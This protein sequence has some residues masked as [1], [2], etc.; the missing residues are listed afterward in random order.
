MIVR[1]YQFAAGGRKKTAGK[2]H[3]L[4]DALGG[5]TKLHAGCLDR[6][7]RVS[8]ALISGAC[9]EAP[10]FE[11]CPA[12]PQL[13]YVVMDEA[14]DRDQ[15]RQHLQEQEVTPII[16]PMRH[17][18]QAIVYDAE[19][20]QLCQEIERS[21]NKIKPF[22]RIAIRYEKLRQTCLAFTQIVSL[23]VMIKQFV[24]PT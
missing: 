10:V 1:A 18:K 9:H 7:I 24:N 21:F 4:W 15:I 13:A 14:C 2:R 17:R 8:L 23:W 20:Y 19:Q 16:L 22:H 11:R 12:M 3:R 6:K 5:A